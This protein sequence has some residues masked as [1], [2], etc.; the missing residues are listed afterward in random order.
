MP[1]TDKQKNKEYGA[2]YYL[3]HKDVHKEASRKWYL[4]NKERVNAFAKSKYIPHPLPRITK[5]E[6]QRKDYMRQW[7]IANKGKNKE[8][9]A[10]YRREYESKKKK[11]DVQYK[12]KCNLRSRLYSAL[13]NNQK[14][15]SA[16]KD[17]GCN[18]QELKSHIEVL[19]KDGMSW[20]NWTNNGWH[21]DH[22]KPLSSFNL[23]QREE[24]LKAVNFKN[25]QPMWATDNIIKSNKII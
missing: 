3:E 20:K 13:K 7:Y 2:K 4:E 10:L 16:I 21:I 18:I 17:L 19:F 8:K 9:V 25:L 22:K 1:Y 6:E 5:T 15:G 11:E 14:S 12:L 24:F 23:S